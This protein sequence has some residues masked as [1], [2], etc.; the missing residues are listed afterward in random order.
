MWEKMAKHEFGFCHCATADLIDEGR[1]FGRRAGWECFL[2]EAKERG[3]P[4]AQQPSRR[5]KRPEDDLGPEH[6]A[7]VNEPTGGNIMTDERQRKAG[8]AD[9]RTHRV[10]NH[11]ERR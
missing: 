1:E 5:I 7:P 2:E 4:S 11:D 8:R 10:A 3:Y 9:A 6:V